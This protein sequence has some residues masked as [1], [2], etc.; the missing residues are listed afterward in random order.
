MILCQRARN[1]VG[2]IVEFVDEDFQEFD[3]IDFNNNFSDFR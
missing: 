1:Q 3:G 2:N